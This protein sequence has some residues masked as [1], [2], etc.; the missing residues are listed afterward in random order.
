M[1][2]MAAGAIS[3]MYMGERFEA[4]PMA[5]PPTDAP[6]HEDREGVGHSRPDGGD[7]EQ[8]R[9]DDQQPFSAEPVAQRAATQRAEQAADQSAAHGPPDLRGA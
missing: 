4:R 9:G 6:H 1:P 2:R 5:T 8:K 7:R 3:A